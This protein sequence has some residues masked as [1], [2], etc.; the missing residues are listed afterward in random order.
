MFWAWGWRGI[1]GC[2]LVEGILKVVME[3]RGMVK[4]RERMGFIKVLVYESIKNYIGE[5]ILEILR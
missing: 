1:W 4:G 2:R 5:L 3:V